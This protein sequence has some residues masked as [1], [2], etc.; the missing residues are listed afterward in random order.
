MLI[1]VG[2]CTRTSY[3]L[4][5]S[6]GQKSPTS[7]LYPD[8][9]STSLFRRW[10]KYTSLQWRYVFTRLR[11]TTNLIIE[12]TDRR[13][14][15]FPCFVQ[16]ISAIST[17]PRLNAPAECSATS[18]RA[19]GGL[20]YTR[21]VRLLLSR[22]RVCIILLLAALYCIYL[23]ISNIKSTEVT[24]CCRS[25]SLNCYHTQKHSFT[26]YYYLYKQKQTH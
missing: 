13:N 10:I 4:S 23:F 8:P 25:L 18:S 2:Y 1:H 12:R 14:A 9:L 7:F 5:N 20:L 6:G 11:I 17:S 15:F 3:R 16:T 21:V 24:D 26:V 19:V 22:P